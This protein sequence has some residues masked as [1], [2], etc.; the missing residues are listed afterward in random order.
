MKRLLHLPKRYLYLLIV[1]LLAEMIVTAEGQ[2]QR[3]DQF[4]SGDRSQAGVIRE[5][6]EK[7]SADDF[8]TLP[9][10]SFHQEA[11]SSRMGEERIL[12]STGL[13]ACFLACG[14]FVLFLYRMVKHCRYRLENRQAY[15]QAHFTVSYLYY[16]SYLRTLLFCS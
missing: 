2:V 5:V 16:L 7:G 6:P 14:I 13:R 8:L 3:T 12:Q 15:R 1:I 10:Q 11:L 4:A 9:R